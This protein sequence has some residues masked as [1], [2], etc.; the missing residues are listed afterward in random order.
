MI[1]GSI[2]KELLAFYQKNAVLDLYRERLTSAGLLGR[3]VQW[4]EHVLILEKLDE[5]YQYDGLVAI[6][7]GDISRIRAYD[8]ELSSV[9]KLLTHEKAAPL[10]DVALLEISAAITMLSKKFFGAALYT[11]LLDPAVVHIGE[12]ED[13]DDD[14]LVMKAWGTAQHGHSSRVLLRLSEVT[15]V[16]ADSLYLRGLSRIRGIQNPTEK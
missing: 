12:P 2:T 4:S 5:Q 16:D 7:P 13:L 8:R 14:F 9:P 3:L 1:D 10:D 15:R 11:E 6:R